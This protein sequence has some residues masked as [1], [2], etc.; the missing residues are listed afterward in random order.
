[1]DNLQD[2]LVIYGV[3]DLLSTKLHHKFKDG[4]DETSQEN[5]C[6]TNSKTFLTKPVR[7]MINIAQQI[8]DEKS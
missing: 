3:C 6:A 7:I 5:D 4:H 1:M 8:H 2:T